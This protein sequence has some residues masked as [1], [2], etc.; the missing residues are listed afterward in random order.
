MAPGQKNQQTSGAAE[1]R[2]AEKMPPDDQRDPI[3]RLESQTI[4]RPVSCTVKI[5]RIPGPALTMAPGQKNQQ[6]SGAAEA[7]RA[8]KM[9]PDDQ[10]DP[11]AR[12]ESQTI[13]R[14]ASCTVKIARN[15]G[16]ALTMAPGQ[17]NQQTSGAAEARRAEKMPPDDQRD[18]IA[19]LESQTIRG[20]PYRALSRSHA[21]LVQH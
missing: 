5:A 9:P 1:A 19:R 12:L 15:P 7:R 11:I 3:A 10:R 20:G 14:T 17:T 6:T 13:R 21:S 2:R 8:E 16:P 4:R 18:P